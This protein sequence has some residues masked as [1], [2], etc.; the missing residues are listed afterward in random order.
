MGHHTAMRNRNVSHELVAALYKRYASALFKYIYTSLSR[1]EEA[2]DILVEVFL[3]AL[4]DQHLIHLNEQQQLAWLF[5]VARNKV[6]DWHRSALRYPATSLELLP[7]SF[8]EHFS[9]TGRPDIL[10][11]QREEYMLLRQQIARLPEMQQEV[12]RLRFILELRHSEI[13]ALLG[14]TEGAVQ[15]LF[16]RAIHSLRT[17]Y[18]REAESRREYDTL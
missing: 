5:R 12:L 10:L 8:E 11:L 2:E 4:K 16:W 1:R 9:E 15:I 6:A 14:K 7:S 3:A 18:Q 17:L 13:A